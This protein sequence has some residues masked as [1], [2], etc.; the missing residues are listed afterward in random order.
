VARWESVLPHLPAED[1]GMAFLPSAVLWKN[2][3]TLDRCT[4]FLESLIKKETLGSLTEIRS[5]CHQILL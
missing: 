5:N 2:A 1:G 4:F 3:S